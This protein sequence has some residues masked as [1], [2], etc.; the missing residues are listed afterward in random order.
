MW[1]GEGIQ[2]P[3]HSSFRS[4]RG[5]RRH[6]HP[7]VPVC[8]GW[9]RGTRVCR[10]WCHRSAAAQTPPPTAQGGKGRGRG[11]RGTSLS[12]KLKCW[13]QRC[14]SDSSSSK[15]CRPTTLHTHCSD[16][17]VLQLYYYCSGSLL[18][19]QQYSWRYSRLTCACTAELVIQ[20]F[21][22]SAEGVCT[23][24]SS[25]ARSKVAVVSISTALLPAQGPWQQQQEALSRE[26]LIKKLAVNPHHTPSTTPHLYTSH[27]TTHQSQAR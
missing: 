1:R 27:H 16:A 22:P 17:V 9:A 8:C 14:Y 4:C 12:L 5:S 6:K 21:W 25:E 18:L 23:M 10:G 19:L 7:H 20:Y 15:P 11:A 26:H 2:T 24:N 3:N 13:W